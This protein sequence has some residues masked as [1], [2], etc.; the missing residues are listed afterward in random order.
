MRVAGLGFRKGTVDF[1]AA[2]LAAG[3]VDALATAAEKAQELAAALPGQRVIGVEVRGVETPTQ[4]PR[5]LA[6]MGT[7]SVAE[8]AA[9]R[10]AGRGARLEGPRQV[11]GGVTLAVA[12]GEGE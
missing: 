9:L 4:S 12:E 1:T 7:G 10:A 6:L 11:I 5:V 2:L 8:A 3:P